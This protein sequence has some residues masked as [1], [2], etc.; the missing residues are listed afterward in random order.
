MR[1]LDAPQRERRTRKDKSI[2]GS[3]RSSRGR[4]G[5]HSWLPA[6]LAGEQVKFDSLDGILPPTAPTGDPPRS[7]WPSE[8][9][10][11]R[12]VIASSGRVLSWKHRSCLGTRSLFRRM[13]GV[14]VI[15]RTR[16]ENPLK[17][18]NPAAKLVLARDQDLKLWRP[19]RQELSSKRFKAFSNL[20][21]VSHRAEN[22]LP[23]RL[24]PGRRE[25][26]K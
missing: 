11:P 3:A 26:R 20:T 21:A 9:P 1:A 2:L 14:A 8:D 6:D 18:P 10:T 19:P 5:S 12:Q 24:F 25:E 4:S 17:G 13:V 15:A 7:R 22:R 16:P 23:R